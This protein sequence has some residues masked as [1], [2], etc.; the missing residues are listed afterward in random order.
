MIDQICNNLF[1][2]SRDWYAEEK[3]DPESQLIYRSPTLADVWLDETGRQERKEQLGK[4][5][6]RQ[7]RRI[8]EKNS[9][10]PVPEQDITP[11]KTKDDLPPFGAPISYDKSSDCDSFVELPHAES[12]V[13]FFEDAA[14]EAPQISLP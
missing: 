6:K 13:Y 4:Q 8:R 10:V 1:D 3:Y 9:S 11:P 14:P 12:E 7:E 5:R 2:S